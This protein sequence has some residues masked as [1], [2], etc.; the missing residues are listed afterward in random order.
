[1]LPTIRLLSDDLFALRHFPS[2]GGT[3]VIQPPTNSPVAELRKLLTH[4]NLDRKLAL[5]ETGQLFDT[6][7]W[8]RVQPPKG[9]R[10]H[11]DLAF[12]APDSR[13]TLLLPEGEFITGKFIDSATDKTFELSYISGK[14]LMENPTYSPRT[15]WS[16][17]W[18]DHWRLWV[19]R[20][21]TL[22]HL[23]FP[24]DLLELW[25]Q[26]AVRGQLDDG[27]TFVRWDESTWEEKRQ[28]LAVNPAPHP[29]F[30]FPGYV[31]VD[32]FHWL[33][34]EIEN[35]NDGDE[36]R[37]AQQLLDRANAVGDK[38]P[39]LRCTAFL[40]SKLVESLGR[41][42]ML[43]ADVE[44]HLR[45]DASLN[46]EIRAKALLEASELVE[47][48]HAL[49]NSSCRIA[50]RL[51]AE[52]DEY[53]RA[54]R[55][56]EAAVRLQPVDSDFANTLGILQYRDGLYRDSIATLTRSHKARQTSDPGPQ[57]SDLAFLAMAHHAVGESDKAQDYLRQLSALC[58]QPEWKTNEEAT[59]F[60]KEARQRLAK[61]P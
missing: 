24:P 15:G 53:R 1:M 58:D 8:R 21:P 14:A 17:R 26:V 23:S 47:G 31:S 10:H 48:A 34:Q 27:G 33:W 54:L 12:F 45:E 50:I 35:A 39:A 4:V 42:L 37:L 56:A 13:F 3:S 51:N 46:P 52:K 59:G 44:R 61:P 5:V 32:R 60:L 9:R 49:N 28:E 40:A 6:R 16:M 19:Q 43:R 11:P 18:S 36:P 2:F 29:D 20:L 55:W 38:A 57:P 7:Y 22:D 25:A 30:P 41:T